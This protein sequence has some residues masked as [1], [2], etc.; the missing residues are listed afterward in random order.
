MLPI[1]DP[2]KI[3]LNN[4]IILACTGGGSGGKRDHINN[5]MIFITCSIFLDIK[6]K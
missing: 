3:P 5:L 2:V 4:I 1:F 6:T